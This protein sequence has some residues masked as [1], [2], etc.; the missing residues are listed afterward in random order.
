MPAVHGRN[1]AK[2]D[3]ALTLPSGTRRAIEAKLGL[4]PKLEKCFHIA[5]DDLQ[6]A[7]RLVVYSGAER[8]PLAHGAE[9]V[10]LVELC[11]NRAAA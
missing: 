4:A 1:G 6:P 8:F 11:R 5:C 10:P 2:I 3:R 7:R 9:A